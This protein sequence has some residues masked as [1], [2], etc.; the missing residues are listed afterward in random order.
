MFA[1]VLARRLEYR[2]LDGKPSALDLLPDGR[3]LRRIDTLDLQVKC[4]RDGLVVRD[5]DLIA[6]IMEGMDMLAPIGAV[7]DSVAPGGNPSLRR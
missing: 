7:Q 2:A 5:V 4:G 1:V 6:L 3:T